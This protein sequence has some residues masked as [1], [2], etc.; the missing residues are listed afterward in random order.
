MSSPS[1]QRA[2][3]FWSRKPGGKLQAG[4]IDQNHAN[5]LMI[6]LGVIRGGQTHPSLFFSL[7]KKNLIVVLVLHQELLLL[8]FFMLLF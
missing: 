5:E 1:V 4:D 2:G 6:R 7:K 8:I 3:G